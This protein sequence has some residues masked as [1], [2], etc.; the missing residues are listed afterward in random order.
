MQRDD[1]RIWAAMNGGETS[2]E[3]P[4][5]DR[6][7]DGVALYPIMLGLVFEALS[8]NP[9]DAVNLPTRRL[10]SSVALE[11][12]AS[13]VRPEYSGT[14]LFEPSTFSEI[15]GLWYRLTLTETA[16][17]QS[18]LVQTIVS[19]V[20]SRD[21]GT[22]RKCVVVELQQLSRILIG[23]SNPY[24]NRATS[25][26]AFLDDS[27]L[28][29]CMRMCAYVLR[30]AINTDMGP[31]GVFCIYLQVDH[32]RLTRF[33]PIRRARGSHSGWLFRL[34]VNCASF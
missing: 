7:A 34:N 26:K 11:T 12:L 27:P 4:P 14:I 31:S 13:L 15:L 21:S 2:A 9:A 5:S 23:L 28:T 22:L 25:H 17:I 3:I 24:V 29:H 16:E 20:K 6:R 32:L 19:L 18:S 33:G 8:T 1:P 30:S 10:S